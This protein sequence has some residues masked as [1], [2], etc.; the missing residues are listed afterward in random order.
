ML[1][2]LWYWAKT[3]PQIKIHMVDFNTQLEHIVKT[4]PRKLLRKWISDFLSGFG[5]SY[6][7]QLY[8]IVRH[9]D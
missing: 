9:L 5:L 3:I 1:E 4:A 6:S 2:V 7:T 8:F